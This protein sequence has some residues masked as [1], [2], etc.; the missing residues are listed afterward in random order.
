M[1]FLR[2]CCKGKGAAPEGCAALMA[3][4]NYYFDTTK[5]GIGFHGDTERR[6]VVAVRTGNLLLAH[7]LAERI[8]HVVKP[9]LAGTSINTVE[10]A[11]GE[12]PVVHQ[13]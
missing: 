3:E 1:E 9:R 4:G 5:C 11:V 12:E 8:R 7:F 2:E 6:K 10:G 13:I